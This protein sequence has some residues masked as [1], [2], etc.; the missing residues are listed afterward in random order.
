M[1]KKQLTKIINFVKPIYQK[2]GKFHAWDHVLAV[3]RNSLMLTSGHYKVNR[4]ILE[5][6]CYL[7]DIGRSVKDEGHP[8]QSV[9]MATPF[10]KR[11]NIDQEEIDD[12]NHAIV[13]H[14]KAKIL[15]ARTIEA[16]L[17]F[18]ADKLE[19]LSVYGFVRVTFWLSEER[20]MS[21]SNALNFLWKYI[22]DI[23]RNYLQTSEAKEIAD[24]EIKVIKI[25]VIQFNKWGRFHHSIIPTNS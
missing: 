17:L 15:S 1:T 4:S 19:M 2:T 16:K 8:G 25:L 10:L 21:I 11:I 7:H 18:D 9:K 12:I 20:N 22:L 13:S 5:A 3:R 24:H 6:A 14:E 23:R